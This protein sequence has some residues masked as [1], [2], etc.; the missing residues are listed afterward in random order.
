MTI[1]GTYLQDLALIGSAVVLARI[2][3]P[4][5]HAGQVRP[6]APRLKPA[7][8]WTLVAWF[9][10]VVF[11]VAWSQALGI[12][13]NDDLPQELGVDESNVALVFVAILV[14]V[15]AP[16]AEELFFRGFCFTALRRRLGMLPAAAA[17]GIIFGAIH[18][19]GTEVE[20]VV[21]LM[22]FGFML[23]LLYV[24]TKSIVPCIVLHALNNS[25]ALG[26]SQDWDAWTLF[27]MIAS[28]IV[29]LAISLPLARRSQAV[30][31]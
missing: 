4:A 20:F 10:F 16:I 24:W 14:C 30:L 17:T 26:V 7:I 29:V 27:A 21:P 18:L 15:L 28:V 23:C 12:T 1:A 9:A 19:G 8:G 2:A 13:E 6:P 11:T 5:G 22:V 31:A 25:L 3:R